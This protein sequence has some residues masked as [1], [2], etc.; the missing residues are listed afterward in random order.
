M[1]DLLVQLFY[2]LARY[3]HIVSTALLLGG[4]LFY[5]MVVPLA[6]GDLKNE[7][8]LYIFAR[9]RWV[10]RSIVYLSAA[11]L[12]LSGVVSTYRNWPI[13]EREE[14]SLQAMVYPPH[15]PPPPSYNVLRPRFWWA[16]HTAIGL[17]SIVIA[18]LL[19]T[20]PRPP[21]RPIQWMRL[22]IV[23]L[24]VTILMAS[25]TRNARLRLSEESAELRDLQQRRL[26]IFVPLVP[27]PIEPDDAPP[28][29]PGD[30]VAPADPA[31]AQPA[32]P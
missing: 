19:V 22:N 32:S 27:T 10:F 29:E 30:S 9:A 6:I 11:M 18:V 24:L 2:L 4:T 1:Y 7:Q 12:L 31:P 23:L 28:A 26:D 15:H 21:D 14:Q 3:L 17:V 20:G 5:E 16:L 8:Q 25:A 13:Y